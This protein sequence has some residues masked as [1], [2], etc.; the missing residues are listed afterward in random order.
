M[1][2]RTSPTEGS[3][4]CWKITLISRVRGEESAFHHLCLEIAVTH[5][6]HP[7][8]STCHP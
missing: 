7:L 4:D 6:S 5:S 1:L 8:V 3:F 2:Y